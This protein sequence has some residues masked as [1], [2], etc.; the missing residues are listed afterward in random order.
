MGLSVSMLKL[1]PLN[2]RTGQIRDDS[3][4]DPIENFTT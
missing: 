4:C 2:L 3:T 1:G